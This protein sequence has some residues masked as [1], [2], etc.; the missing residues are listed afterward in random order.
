[1]YITA[2]TQAYFLRVY[3]GTVLSKNQEERTVL[4]IARK[5]NKQNNFAKAKA[6]LEKNLQNL[7]DKLPISSRYHYALGRSYFGLKEFANAENQFQKVANRKHENNFEIYALYFLGRVNYELKKYE[8]AIKMFK[9]AIKVSPNPKIIMKVYPCLIISHCKMN[10]E[11]EALLQ[12]EQSMNLDTDEV[13]VLIS[14]GIALLRLKRYEEGVV[15]INKAYL[16]NNSFNY[17]LGLAY[18]KAGQYSQAKQYLNDSKNSLKHYYIARATVKSNGEEAEFKEILFV[19]CKGDWS[20]VYY[21]RAQYY[22][23]ANDRIL[24]FETYKKAYALNHLHSPVDQLSS[25]QMDNIKSRIDVLNNELSQE[26]EIKEGERE[27]EDIIISDLDEDLDEDLDVEEGDGKD[28]EFHNRNHNNNIIHNNDV[29]NNVEQ[30]HWPQS[31]EIDVIVARDLQQKLLKQVAAIPEVE[32]ISEIAREKEKIEFEQ[33]LKI[34]EISLEKG[35][36][37]KRERKEGELLKKEMLENVNRLA[38]EVAELQEKLAKEMENNKR[39]VQKLRDEKEILEKERG[40]REVEIL[41][42]NRGSALDYD[43]EHCVEKKEESEEETACV[44]G[45]V[46][47]QGDPFQQESE[48]KFKDE[49]SNPD[50]YDDDDDDVDSVEGNEDREPPAIP[51]DVQSRNMSQKIP[52]I[53]IVKIE[54]KQK[55]INEL[56]VCEINRFDKEYLEELIKFVEKNKGI[57]SKRGIGGDTPLHILSSRFNDYLKQNEGNLDN[58]LIEN[59][60]EIAKRVI[61]NG[62]LITSNDEGKL[63]FDC[64]FPLS[65]SESQEKG[66]LIDSKREFIKTM[67]IGPTNRPEID[68]DAL[69]QNSGLKDYSS[70]SPSMGNSLLESFLQVLIGSKFTIGGRSRNISKLIKTNIVVYLAHLISIKGKYSKPA[71]VNPKSLEKMNPEIFFTI[72]LRI[73]LQ[74]YLH[75]KSMS[76]DSGQKETISIL[77]IEL[78]SLIE[79]IEIAKIR[80]AITRLAGQ[81]ETNYWIEVLSTRITNRIKQL[82]DGERYLL[83]AGI[84]DHSIYI[85]FIRRSKS[86]TFDIAIY[87]LGSGKTAHDTME[88]NNEKYLP[89]V[90]KVQ[91]NEF[92]LSSRLVSLFMHAKCAQLTGNEA[93]DLIL[94]NEAFNRI[95]KQSVNNENVKY[96]IEDVV[97]MGYRYKRCQSVN[98]CVVK[99]YYFAVQLLYQSTIRYQYL[100]MTEIQFLPLKIYYKSSELDMAISQW[101]TI[102]NVDQNIL[103]PLKDV[104]RKKLYKLLNMIGNRIDEIGVVDYGNKNFKFLTEVAIKLDWF[105]DYDELVVEKNSIAKGGQGEV[106]KAKWNG[107]TVVVKKMQF[108]VK[109]NYDKK[110]FI[111]RQLKFI[112]EFRYPLIVQF[113][114]ISIYENDFYIVMEHV[115]TTLHEFLKEMEHIETF[116]F[117]NRIEIAYQISLAMRFLHNKGIIHCDLNSY[118]VL[119][120]RS[121]LIAKITDFGLSKTAEYSS[122]EI[123]GGHLRWKSPELLDDQ[124]RTPPTH[125]KESDTFAL[126]MV[127]W[128]IISSKEPYS[129]VRIGPCNRANYIWKMGNG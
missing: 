5:Y 35:K 123:G 31:N 44:Q 41:D 128:Q 56:R 86:Q 62:I 65:N 81:S 115:D 2:N 40:K 87:N 46:C 1:M 109:E 49:D 89:F 57:S 54:D 126:G 25:K 66:L 3:M 21:R 79:L 9:Q 127:F 121:K 90:L 107:A 26:I 36:E 105:I 47:F 74:I 55:N 84:S 97:N 48:L 122:I 67:I 68:I 91:E 42:R 69:I 10:S 63:P 45:G 72:R 106:F 129:E 80:S 103:S 71:L 14:K 75:L 58:N 4:D 78:S 85:E 124:A 30:P 43:L 82:K 99:N 88:N 38:K 94:R 6:I 112:Q 111:N 13:Q 60:I 19:K 118:N 12:L 61:S 39:E 117:R 8:K 110:R 53:T 73:L 27:L 95:Y 76:N 51:E 50:N 37:K 23:K 16:K 32:G 7:D 22:D 100:R 108:S 70:S 11:E 28:V 102:D 33:E 92:S 15:E 113:Y 24:A 20:R 17:E 64:L 59:F 98:N 93:K 96:K 101:G 18:Y 77:K 34:D 119:I 114:G 52:K 104:D 125:T 29:N 116:T 83:H 120:D